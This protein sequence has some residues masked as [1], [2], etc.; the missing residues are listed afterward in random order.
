[1]DYKCIDIPEDNYNY[2]DSQSA[3][4]YCTYVRRTHCKYAKMVYSVL[5]WFLSSAWVGFFHKR[6]LGETWSYCWNAGSVLSFGIVH[7]HWQEVA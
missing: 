1:M 4:K 3:S 6:W 5:M 7:K 2:E